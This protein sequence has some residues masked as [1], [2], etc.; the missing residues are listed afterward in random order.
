LCGIKGKAQAQKGYNDDLVM[1]LGIAMYI[2]DTALRYRQRG[3]DITKSALMN[4][5]VNRTAYQGGYN[6]G[7][8]RVKNPYEIDLGD[9][10]K[11]NI[12]W[13]L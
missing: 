6:T 4:I 5:G 10:N 2:R 1:S 12:N 13:L 8:P 7:N 9:G 11:E 3:I